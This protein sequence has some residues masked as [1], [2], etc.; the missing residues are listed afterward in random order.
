[1][2]LWDLLVLYVMVMFVPESIIKWSVVTLLVVWL[3]VPLSYVQPL[4]AAMPDPI[5]RL[6]I[7]TF[8]L[9][10]LVTAFVSGRT[11]ADNILARISICQVDYQ[12][13][14]MRAKP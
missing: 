12:I 13:D 8:L 1:M 7:P 2:I 3:V 4:V 5:L 14:K 10:V 11:A 9:F 6:T